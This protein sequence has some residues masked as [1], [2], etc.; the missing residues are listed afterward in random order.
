[1]C[2]IPS[3]FQGL[4]QYVIALKSCNSVSSLYLILLVI[5]DT[6]HKLLG[7]LFVR[8]HV[9]NLSVFDASCNMEIEKTGRSSFPFSQQSG[10]EH[11][12]LVL[13]SF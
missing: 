3:L 4:Y 10:K 13:H 7:L 2:N 1:M 5:W 11:I 8:C 6:F 9:W 12:D